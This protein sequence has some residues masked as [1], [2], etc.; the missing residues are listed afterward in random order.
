MNDECLLTDNEH[1]SSAYLLCLI[2]VLSPK[3]L[4]HGLDLP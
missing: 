4:E 2:L 1:E 3:A